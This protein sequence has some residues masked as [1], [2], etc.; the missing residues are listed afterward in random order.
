MFVSS[1][2]KQ[3]IFFLIL[4]FKRWSNE[5]LDVQDYSHVFMIV[6]PVATSLS[7]VCRLSAQYSTSKSLYSQKVPLKPEWRRWLIFISCAAQREKSRAQ[8]YLFDN[9]I[10]NAS[11]RPNN[12]I[13]CSPICI[14]CSHNREEAGTRGSSEV[15]NERWRSEQRRR[16]WVSAIKCIYLKTSI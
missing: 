10:C 12:S 14:Q 16:C 15:S 6:W 11:D 9:C 7:C 5:L 8:S 13:Q 2:Q 1:E 4:D 3:L